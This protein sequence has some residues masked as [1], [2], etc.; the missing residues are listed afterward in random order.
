MIFVLVRKQKN[1]TL[2]QAICNAFY[3]WNTFLSITHMIIIL[4]DVKR[5]IVNVPKNFI[6]IYWIIIFSL[7]LLVSSF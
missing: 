5:K 6:F 7:N 2:T 4:K 1:C 3:F